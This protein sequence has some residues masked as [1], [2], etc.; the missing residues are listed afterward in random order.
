MNVVGHDDVA[1]DQ[2][3]SCLFPNVMQKLMDLVA[4]KPS[5]S[6]FCTNG[7]EDD[8]GVIRQVQDPVRR[9]LAGWL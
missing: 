5:F 8:C 7:I 1:T 6:V 2:P 4:G 9:V 3:S